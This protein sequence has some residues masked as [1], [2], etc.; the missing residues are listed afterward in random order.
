M[1]IKDVM[2][3]EPL[4]D[5]GPWRVFRYGHKTVAISHQ[6]GTHVSRDG[7]LVPIPDVHWLWSSMQSR[8]F[9]R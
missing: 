3:T 2:L 8:A 4:P 1:E 5:D 6:S 9:P 7:A